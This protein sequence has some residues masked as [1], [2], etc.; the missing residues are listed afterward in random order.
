MASCEDVG[1]SKQD[2]HRKRRKAS[3]ITAALRR[4]EKE[5]HAHITPADIRGAGQ[6]VGHE[7]RERILG[8]VLT[9]QALLLEIPY[10]TAMTGVSRFTTV[11]FSVA[12]Y[13][14]ARGRLPV[15]VLRDLLRLLRYE[16]THLAAAALIVNPDRPGRGQLRVVRRRPLQ[17]SR[18]T[19]PRAELK[20]ELLSQGRRRT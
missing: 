20:R 1:V 15:G 19:R 13:C 4:I 7:W 9:V 6:A 11:T 5:L 18:M 17:Y 14:Q 12:A 2:P 8:P 16:L 10:A 3:S